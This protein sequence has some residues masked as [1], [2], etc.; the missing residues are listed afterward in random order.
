M[1]QPAAPSHVLWGPCFLGSCLA[2]LSKNA[3][4]L[5]QPRKRTGSDLFWIRLLGPSDSQVRRKLGS[6]L[7]SG[8]RIKKKNRALPWTRT[9]ESKA[10]RTLPWTR[11][12]SGGRARSDSGLDS[13]SWFG[14]AWCGAG[15]FRHLP[16]GIGLG[17]EQPPP[18][19]KEARG[20]KKGRW[21]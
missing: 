3:A 13:G 11:A 16:A 9:P 17:K 10:N 6:S 18:Q 4:C 2:A 15:G 21:V 12:L 14:R 7:D 1:T 5:S 8:S 20:L 19:D